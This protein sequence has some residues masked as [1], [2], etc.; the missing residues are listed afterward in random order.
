MEHLELIPEQVDFIISTTYTEVRYTE[1][2]GVMVRLDT[3]RIGH[4]TYDATW[5]E[6]DVVAEVKC[7]TLNFYELYHNSFSIKG[8]QKPWEQYGNN[9][10]NGFYVVNNS[11]LLSNVNAVY[12]PKNRFDLKH[13]LITGNDSFI[14]LIAGDYSY[15]Y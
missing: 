5:I 1:N 15:G 8:D 4:D 2:K 3:Q 12:D 7:T 10:F 13:Y 11:T 14:E 9:A 6:F